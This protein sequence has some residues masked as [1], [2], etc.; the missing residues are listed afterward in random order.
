MHCCQLTHPRVCVSISPC[1]TRLC[2]MHPSCDSDTTPRPLCKSFKSHESLSVLRYPSRQLTTNA[3]CQ[4][5]RHHPTRPGADSQINRGPR[6][7]SSRRCALKPPCGCEHAGA[8]RALQRVALEEKPKR[9]ARVGT[10]P[11]ADMSTHYA[12]I[13]CLPAY[14]GLM[15]QIAVASV[16]KRLALAGCRPCVVAADA[17]LLDVGVPLS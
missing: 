17:N 13:V 12:V 8:P 4:T 6:H 16:A 5:V 15:C 10:S 9:R 1:A 2:V 14:Y 11:R 7:A 3:F